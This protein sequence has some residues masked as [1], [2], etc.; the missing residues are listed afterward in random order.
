MFPDVEEAFHSKEVESSSYSIYMHFI[1]GRYSSLCSQ[2]SGPWIGAVNLPFHRVT[3]MV[4]GA[5][6]CCSFVLRA[7]FLSVVSCSFSQ[8]LLC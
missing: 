3:D 1:K 8:V 7:A 4:L 2:L 5:W 6:R